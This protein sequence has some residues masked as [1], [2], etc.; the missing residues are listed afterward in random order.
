[1]MNIRRVTAKYRR[2]VLHVIGWGSALIQ[3]LLKEE[4]T[5]VTPQSRR[6]KAS[7]FAPARKHRPF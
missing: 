5:S 1:M 6:R 3:K 2:D 4:R 7:S